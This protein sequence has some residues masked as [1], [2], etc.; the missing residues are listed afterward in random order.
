MEEQSNFDLSK[1]VTSWTKYDIVQ[2]IDVIDSSETIEA[3]KK[4]EIVINEPILKWFLNIRTLKSKT[5]Q[6]WDDIQRYPKEKKLFALL[7][8]IFTHYKV[9]DV[10]AVSGNN[11]K[12]GLLHVNSGDKMFTNIRSALVES[13][14]SL[15]SYRRSTEVPYDFSLLF[16]NGEIG[17]LAK[18]LLIDRLALALNQVISE[19]NLFSI[20]EQYHF[21]KALG[22]TFGE[23]KRWLSGRSI[24]SNENHR[25]I[26]NL[27]VSKFYSIAE[28][29]LNLEGAKEI[30]FLGENGDGKSLILMALYLAFR[31]DLVVNETE[32]KET[33]SVIDMI[34]NAKGLI[35]N[36]QDSSDREYGIGKSTVLPNVYAYGTHR[37]RY[38]KVDNPEKY[39]FMSLFDIDQTLI[40]PV[41]WLRSQKLIELEKRLDG[42][43]KIH[44][45]R[46]YPVNMAVSRLE[47][48][49]FEILE[50]NVSVEIGTEEV[51]FKEKGVYINFDQLSEGYRSVLIFV[52]DLLVRL[53][54]SSD[55]EDIDINSISGVVLIDEIDQHLHPSWQKIVVNR[56]R[57]V[58]PKVQFIMTTHSPTI[59]QGASDEAIIYR[60]FRDKETAETKVSEPVYRRDLDDLMVNSLITH[61][62]FGLESA[63]LDENN[64]NADTSDDYLQ[65][66]IN[67]SVREELNKK[68]RAG[69]NFITD[70]EID[71]L[72]SEIMKKELGD[73]KD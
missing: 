49:L 14:A 4:Q 27:K 21:D 39:G 54:L 61:P 56:L 36:G 46:G 25:Y 23:F 7:S 26:E 57:Q 40:N 30:Y 8:V 1:L 43:N 42:K 50:R 2:V 18:K 11:D 62:I 47:T 52:I 32:R 64:E 68:R 6:Y 15:P 73:D 29:E 72:I 3:Y 37:G 19:D 71:D 16:E 48:L 63:R 20:S 24:I 13:G 34:D 9:I 12:G 10:F 67:K 66:R 45:K 33:G 17:L 58:F 70:Q 53:T 35:L 38:A 28:C 60:V 51:K 31:G 65:Y 59:I 69:A 44:K 55:K 41:V 22:L 5:P